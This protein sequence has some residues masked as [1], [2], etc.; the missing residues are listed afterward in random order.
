MHDSLGSLDL[1]RDFP[2]QLASA[3]GRKVIAYDRLS[4]GRS[5]ANP[6][7]L[8]TDFVYAEA[9]QGFKALLQHYSIQQFIVMGHSVGGGMSVVIAS[10]Y[11]EQ[12]RGLI[13]IAAQYEVEE[14][15]LSGIREAKIGFAQL[16]QL[17]RLAK[18]HGDKAQWVLDAWTE[19]WLSP[20]F[21]QWNLE[22]YVGKVQYPS[23]IIHGELDEYGTTAQ[24]QKLF[25]SIQGDAEL[26]I[27]EGLHHM[28]HKEQPAL[29]TALIC[30]FVN[31]LS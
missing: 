27:L 3:S 30:D 13:S 2:A 15:T 11:T 29:V 23:L 5:S 9:Q 12:C 6:D 25:S 20:S 22:Q 17:E 7:V 8:S 18:Y 10:E 28:P 14:L 24:A 4:F 1:W 19:T 16:G 31:D 26:E 21:R